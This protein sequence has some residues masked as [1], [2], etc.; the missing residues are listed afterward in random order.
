M[1]GYAMGQV[2]RLLS[3]PAS[4]LRFWEKEIPFLSPRKDVFGRRIYSAADLCMLARLRHLAL[5]LGLGIHAAGIAL[6]DELG[7]GDQG[8]KAA[9]A[10]LRSSLLGLRAEAG[11]LSGRLDT[12]KEQ[13]GTG[14]DRG[15]GTK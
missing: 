11:E 5:D 2:E 7:Q 13:D 1:S 9:I 15:R 12:L 14:P 8:A 10:E 4:T 6:E 3:L